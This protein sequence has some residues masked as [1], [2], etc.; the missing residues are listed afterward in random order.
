M[1]QRKSLKSCSSEF[2][3]SVKLKMYSTFKNWNQNQTKPTLYVLVWVHWKG[4][5]TMTNL[6]KISIP[7]I[8]IVVWKYH[9]PFKETKVP[10]S[11]MHKMSLKY[12]AIYH[13]PWKLLRSLRS[14]SKELKRN[15]RTFPMAKHGD[16]E[17]SSKVNKYNGCEHVKYI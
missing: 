2:E 1:G 10:Q 11:K 12:L 9:S 13:T 6:A 17:N 14:T 5:E 15:I 7:N 3:V 16:N 8:Q 4:L